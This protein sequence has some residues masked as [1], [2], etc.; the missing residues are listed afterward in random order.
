[1]HVLVKGD[2]TEKDNDGACFGFVR[3]GGCRG[4]REFPFARLRDLA[5]CSTDEVGVAASMQ[6]AKRAAAAYAR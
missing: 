5:T 4:L 1:M 6:W 3:V 2:E